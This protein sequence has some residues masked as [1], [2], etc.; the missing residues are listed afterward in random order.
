MKSDGV[1]DAMSCICGFA[2]IATLIVFPVCFEVAVPTD[3]AVMAV[4]ARPATT[5]RVRE[6]LP[7]ANLSIRGV[8]SF[9]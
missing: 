4:A 9:V 1:S 8:L 6:R 2:T 7:N 5:R 3:A